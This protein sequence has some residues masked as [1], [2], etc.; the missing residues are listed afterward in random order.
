IYRPEKL[1]RARRQ[2]VHRDVMYVHGRIDRVVTAENRV[3]LSNQSAIDYDVL[4]IA[5]GTRVVPE[6]TEGLTGTGWRE[7]IFDFYTREGA[8]A[9]REKLETWQGGRLVID[10]VEMP[11][12]CPVAPLEFAFLAD[13]YFTKRGIRD[14][15]DI[16][17]VT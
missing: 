12:K 1:T 5:T 8:M 6:E 15:V 13:W 16:T 9:L 14:R 10:I 4:I 17:Y 7:S 3:Y 2:Q 11:I